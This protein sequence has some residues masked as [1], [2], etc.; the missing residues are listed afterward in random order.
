M[1][2]LHIALILGNQTAGSGLPS[3]TYMISCEAFQGRHSST[4]LPQRYIWPAV[5]LSEGCEQTL[6]SQKGGQ[7]PS[8]L[9]APAW[10]IAQERQVVHCMIIL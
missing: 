7:L 6:T 2:D 8:A 9:L 4:L 3:C 1:P 10:L 5:L